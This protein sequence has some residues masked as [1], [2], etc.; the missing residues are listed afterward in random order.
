MFSKLKV[1]CMCHLELPADQF[2]SRG[3]KRKDS[4]A[5][6][7]KCHV[8]YMLRRWQK[9][10]IKSIDYLGGKCVDCKQ[11]YHPAIFQFHHIDP[12]QKESSWKR[13]RYRKWEKVVKELDKCIL[14]CANC[15]CLRHTHVESYGSKCST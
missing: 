7:K 4:Y 9:L 10:K 15:H 2:Y 1:C 6:C 14:L 11:V 5:H 3:S 12:S 13:F 8:N